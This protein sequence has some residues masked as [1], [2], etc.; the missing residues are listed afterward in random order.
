MSRYSVR[1]EPRGA[2]HL[3]E[4]GIGYEETAECVHADT[5]FGALCS[6]WATLYGEDA[7][8]R[9]LLP[10][11]SEGWEPPLVFS[12]AF[13]R[14]GPVRFYPKPL[15]PPPGEPAEWKDV[16]WVSERVFVAWLRGDPA[17]DLQPAHEGRVKMT[18]AEHEQAYQEMRRA[19]PR[20]DPESKMWQVHRVPRVTLDVPSN[21]SELWHFGRL[22]FAPGC[23]LHLWV[24]LRGPADFRERFWTA[25]RVLGDTGIGGDRSSGHGLFEV[26]ASEEDPPWPESDTRFVTLAPVY[27]PAGQVPTLLS[28]ACAYK[29]VTRTGWIGSVLPTPYRRK[30][31]RLLVEGSVLGGSGA[32]VWGGLADVTPDQ[33]PDLPHRVYRWGYAFPAGVSRP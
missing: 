11:G 6:V 16:E 33:A 20:A 19:D 1:L 18:R 8:A 31:V 12:S 10:D 2:F 25:L 22:Q 32:R 28:D 21:A 23:G 26:D 9:D 13:P 30:A 27:P 15:L 14:A 29:L 7:V 5:F 4:R 24:E 17:Q 3:G